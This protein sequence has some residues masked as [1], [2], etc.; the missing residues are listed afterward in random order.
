MSLRSISK[1]EAFEKHKAVAPL[2]KANK[3]FLLAV[4]GLDP[5]INCTI[6]QSEI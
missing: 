3:A 5:S 1:L 4:L 2:F 6:S